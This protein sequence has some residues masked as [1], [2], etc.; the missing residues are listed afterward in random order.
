MMHPP[1]AC[2]LLLAADDASQDKKPYFPNS[3]GVLNL[4]RKISMDFGMKAI[5]KKVNAMRTACAARCPRHRSSL[6][7]P[8][9]CSLLSCDRIDSSTG[10]LDIVSCLA[11]MPSCIA[12]S[13]CSFARQMY[14]PTLRV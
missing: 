5:E 1:T 7:K 12:L 2:H 14:G 4:A 8:W 6:A 3:A 11:G 10:G 9:P 13:E